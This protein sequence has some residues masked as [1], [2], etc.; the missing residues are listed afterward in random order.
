MKMVGEQREYIEHICKEFQASQRVKDSLNNSIQTLAKDLYNEETHF[1]F[2]LIQNAEDNTYD[3]EEPSL[4]FQLTKTDPTNTHNSV[5]ALIISNNEIGFSSKNVDAICAVGK[6]TKSKIQG[7]IGEK[8]IGFK[9]VF[10]ITTKPHIFSGGYRFCLPEKDEETGLGYIVPHWLN[11]YPK[12]INPCHTTIILPLDKPDFGYE[13]INDMLQ[14]IA[15]E[16]ILFLSKLKEIHIR[17]DTGDRLTIQK[18]N[19]EKPLV[20]I[21]IE[22]ER[23]GKPLSVIYEFLLYTNTVVKPENVTHEKRMGIDE[24]VVSIAFPTDEKKE[25]TGKIFAYLPVHSNTGL[26]FLVNADFILPSSREE[27]RN[28]PW[29]KWLMDCVANL[30]ADALPRLKEKGQ[31]TVAIL[32]SLAKR[33]NE[34]DENS[35]FYSIVEA[36]RIALLS[37]E[38]LPADDG[39][40]VSAKQAK[41]TGAEWLRKLLQ[42][43]QLRQLSKTED[44]LKW[45]SG[46][47]TAKHNLWK[48]IREELK[49][50]EITPDSFVRNIEEPFF[51]SQTDNWMIVF[52]NHLVNRPAL[53]RKGDGYQRAGPLRTKPFI[54][55]QNGSHVLP[56]RDDDSPNVY[57]PTITYTEYPI[58][59]REIAEKTLEFLQENLLLEKPS[60]VDEVIK[61]I[62][63]KYT[64]D[65]PIISDDEHQLHMKKIRSAY[66]E[67]SSKDKQRLKEKLKD[68]AFIYAE[69]LALQQNIYKKPTKLYFANDDLLMY[70]DGN[71]DIWFVNSE[72]DDPI[73]L[74]M[75]E[76]LGVTDT[77]RVQRKSKGWKGYISIK[78]YSGRHERGLSGF[79]PNIKV[80]GIKYALQHPTMERSQ[81]VWDTF[82]S[83]FSD[84]IRGYVEWS[85]REDFSDNASTYGK[86]EQIS[87]FG[88]LLRNTAWLPEANGD[89]YKPNKLKLDDLPESFGRDEN[90]SNQLDMKKDVVARLAEE[91]GVPVDDVEWLRTHPKEFQQFRASIAKQELPK[92]DFPTRSSADHARRRGKQRE[93]FPR[94]TNKVYEPRE[95][96]V[97]TSRGAIDPDEWLRN[98]YT[99]EKEQMVC[100]VCQN[101]MPFKKRNGNYYFECIEVLDRK[102]LSKEHEPQFLALCPLCAAKY[103]EFVKHDEQALENMKTALVNTK[104]LEIPIQLDEDEP[105]TI[106]FVEIHRQDLQGILSPE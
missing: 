22:G 3:E 29:N 99:N 58:V 4:S 14:D 64:P 54:R 32:E 91:T 44:H 73:L 83:P 66:S 48:Y 60:L 77:V 27:I 90:L 34:L 13:K 69:N 74:T 89:F 105:S 17:T 95:R 57:L 65:H 6:T 36:F 42:D 80:D 76:D 5:G 12:R 45:V 30:L 68:T 56:F 82:A 61:K 87:I 2:E 9:S 67:A 86:K 25:N 79:D 7:Y 102:T 15:P 88:K 43:R 18:D 84:C 55:L 16:T 1:I 98:M 49:V 101:E 96:S 31:L 71:E 106:R 92:P 78:A 97:R 93:N 53:W 41:L 75:L 19:S 81:Y 33:T 38:L 100:Q 40:F 21:R 72:Y 11:N 51:K 26:P 46:D 94:L 8:G 28:V 47:I 104:G 62:A 52:Y 37:Q 50:E 63:P 70:F 39:T 10:Q 24:R 35:L 103:K 85:S 23:Q 20:Q 59:K